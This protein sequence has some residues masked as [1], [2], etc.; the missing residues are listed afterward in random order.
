MIP[1]GTGWFNNGLSFDINPAIVENVNSI[2]ITNA[3]FDEVYVDRYTDI[4]LNGERTWTYGTVFYAQFNGNLFAGNAEFTLSNIDTLRIKRRIVG[5]FNWITFVEKPVTTIDDINITFKDTL[6]A[7]NIPHEYVLVPV[8][9]GIEGTYQSATI[10]PIFDGLFIVGKDTIYH[11]FVNLNQYENLDYQR[12][13]EIS[14][15]KPFDSKY[16][17]IINNSLINYD[18]TTISTTF[19]ELINS[20]FTIDWE[21]GWRYREK[22]KDFL[23]DGKAKIIK[24]EYGQIKLCAISGTSISDTANGHWQNVIT[25]FNVTQIGDINSSN[26]LY[27]NGFINVNVEGS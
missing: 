3:K 24:D 16:P 2:S 21:N 27:N 25:T 8:K 23:T 1:I 15:I 5:T 14:E 20:N 12:N 7:S 18:T 26:D 4:D 13:F 19:V 10:T 6:A 17:Y 9:N 22:L 11:T